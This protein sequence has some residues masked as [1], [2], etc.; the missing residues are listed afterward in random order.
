[1]QCLVSHHHSPRM[2]VNRIYTVKESF[3]AGRIVIITRIAAYPGSNERPICLSK[4]AQKYLERQYRLTL[5][6]LRSITFLYAF[7]PLSCIFYRSILSKYRSFRS[8]GN[9]VDITALSPPMKRY[10]FKSLFISSHGLRGKGGSFEYNL[11]YNF[12]IFKCLMP[13]GEHASKRLGPSQGI[14]GGVIGEARK[15]Q[16]SRASAMVWMSAGGP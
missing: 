1:M 3:L 2:H 14:R 11:C 9:G 15:Q 5:L 7:I 4:H 8:D 6:C 16:V 10:S 13:K 12:L